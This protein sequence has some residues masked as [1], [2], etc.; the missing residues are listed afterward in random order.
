VSLNNDRKRA[1]THT[2]LYKIDNFE[3]IASLI[4]EQQEERQ[5]LRINNIQKALELLDLEYKLRLSEDDF[6]SA[7]DVL[8]DSKKASSFISLTGNVQDRWIERYVTVQL[9]VQEGDIFDI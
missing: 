1:C 2:Q 4:R 7:I 3:L 9:L 6:D 5:Q 8:G